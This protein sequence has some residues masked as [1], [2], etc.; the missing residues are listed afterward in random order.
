MDS[1]AVLPSSVPALSAILQDTVLGRL[2]SGVHA[3]DTVVLKR[4]APAPVVQFFLQQ[5]PLVMWGGVVLALVLLAL[6][7]RWA[8]PRRSAFVAW[9]RGWPRQAWVAVVA[10]LAVVGLASLFLGVKSYD[11]IMNDSRFCTGCHIFMPPG[12]V[13]QV[14][15]T[16][17]YTLVSRLSGKH[18][19]L[20]CH[21]CHEFHA[22]SEARKMVLWMSGFRYTEE[23]RDKKGAPAHGFVPRDICES[24][25]VQGAAKETWQAISS[26]AGHRLHLQSDSASGKLM[27][28]S[29]CLTCHAQTAHVF[30]PTDTTCSQRG[31]HLTDETRIQLGRM[32]SA[33]GLHCTVC[34]EFT[35][36]VPA[37]ASVDS[38]GNTLRPARQQCLGCHAMTKVLPDFNAAREPHSG[39]CG[40][41]H[42][43]HTQATPAAAVKSC[44][45]AQC[46]LTWRD[47]PFHTGRVHRKVAEDCL[48]CHQPH[49]ARVDAS[50]CA[51]CHTSVRERTRHR[52]PLP[53]DTTRALQRVSQVPVPI[54]EEPRGKGDVAPEDHFS[55]VFLSRLAPRVPRPVVDSFPHARHRTL[56]CIV[57]HS[58]SAGHG[59]LNFEQPRGCQICHHQAPATSKCATCHTPD[60]TG[61]AVTLPVHLTVPRE[62]PRARDVRFSHPTHSSIQCIECHVTPVTMA[63][64]PAVTTCRDC[65]ATHHEAR[66]DCASC[67]TGYDIKARHAFS[68]ESSH[69]RCDA[70]HAPAT[71]RIL[72][73]LRS[74][75]A[76]CHEPQRTSHY[77]D[78]ECVTCHLLRE[79]A[80]WKRK[81]TT[82]DSG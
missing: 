23:G 43:P 40:V 17:D 72:E 76:T 62:P 42:N 70:C 7:L 74:F 9:V 61:P 6:F 35:A 30:T 25:H 39:Q 48:T 46:H 57:C 26:T 29:E 66:R 77:E 3:A 34:H 13:V 71:V 11:Y 78:R 58:T 75:C 82:P 55:G 79:P 31:C 14:A 38:A 56:S 44:A 80:Q 53:F 28:G 8:W 59:E 49:A 54:E 45:S 21:T 27:S 51:G 64:T 68:G 67:H 19:S 52:P 63:A 65:H 22:M 16:G 4:F 5:S 12:Q 73:P 32:T 69:Q 1:A 15:D 24:C 41:C 10:G 18:D 2:P 81:L 47:I 36:A 37:L 60:E 50:D 20:N 33:T